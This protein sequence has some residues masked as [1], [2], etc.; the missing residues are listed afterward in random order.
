LKVADDFTFFFTEAA[1]FSNWFRCTFSV[2]GVTFNCGEQYM[3]YAKARLFN[4]TSTAEA[5][6]K[7]SHPKEQKKLGRKVQNFNQV[8]WDQRCINILRAGLFEKFSQNPELQALLLK[9]APTT[10]V[11][12]SPY[13]RIWGVGLRETDP[14]ILDPKNWKGKNLLGQVLMLIREDLSVLHSKLSDT[15][16]TLSSASSSFSSR[17]RSK[18]L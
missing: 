1:P 7:A 16:T 17:G 13:D 4:D 8:I 9:T 11:E 6:L 14:R 10:L 12:A 2:H 15:S 18:T 5:I 3:M